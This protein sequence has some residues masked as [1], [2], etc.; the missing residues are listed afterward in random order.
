VQRASVGAA[1][2]C[3]IEQGMLFIKPSHPPE[4]FAVVVSLRRAV[5]SQ[6]LAAPVRRVEH[7]VHSHFA[8]RGVR[9]GTL[10]TFC[11]SFTSL[12]SSSGHQSKSLQIM[13]QFATVR[14]FVCGAYLTSRFKRGNYSFR[15]GLTTREM[16]PGAP[17]PRRPLFYALLLS[18]SYSLL[19][20][21][22]QHLRISPPFFGNAGFQLRRQ[23]PSN[24]MT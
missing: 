1:T 9:C 13:F 10:V 19:Q 3:L 2:A 17:P 6:P 7:S 4:L 15:I 21:E 20:F 8:Y 16:S 12:P 5:R 23:F 11:N 24:K 14:H 22:S 18:L